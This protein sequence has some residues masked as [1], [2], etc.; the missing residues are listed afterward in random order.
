[1]SEDMSE[2]KVTCPRCGD[3]YVHFTSV[4][5]IPGNDNYEASSRVRGDLIQ[6]NGECENCGGGFS[7]CFGFHK[8]YTMT[9]AQYEKEAKTYE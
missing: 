9:W 8:G 4:A 7:L 5:Q 3:E 6:L 2:G 1:M